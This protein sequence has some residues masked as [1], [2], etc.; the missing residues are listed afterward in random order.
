[1]K[2]KGKSGLT[3]T[4]V[5][6]CM[7][8][9]GVLF[10][11]AFAG[12]SP[13]PPNMGQ[14][15]SNMKQLHL[16]TQQMALDGTTAGKTNLG[17]P[18]DSGETIGGWVRQ[19]VPEYLG[20]NDI[21]KLLSTRGRTVTWNEFPYFTNSA[22]LVYAVSDASPANTIFLSTANFTNTPGGGDPLN[23]KSEPYRTRGFAIFRKAGDGGIY[24]SR[25]IRNTNLL[26]GYAPLCH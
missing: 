22:L 9:F 8:V 15:L 3:L 16:A 18:G 1:M 4:E 25:N 2:F 6:V 24:V 19:L 17:W 14:T 12:L 23:P 21:C 11:V 13:K 20:S 7:G 10:A 26:G 5:L